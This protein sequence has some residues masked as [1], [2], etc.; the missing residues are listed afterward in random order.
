MLKNDLDYFDLIKSDFNKSSATYGKEAK[1]QKTVANSLCNQL[2]K[3]CQLS[4]KKILDI[5]CGSGFFADFLLRHNHTADNV[6]QLDIALDMCRQSSLYNNLV[7]NANMEY[8]PFSNNSF[9][10]IYSNFTMQWLLN[11]D[12]FFHNLHKIIKPNGIIFMSAVGSNTFVEMKSVAN[13]LNI[14]LPIMQ[15]LDKDEL[16]QILMLH[17][18]SDIEVRAKRI[19]RVY[20]NLFGLLVFIKNIGG[21]K[22]GGRSLSI[23]DLKALANSYQNKFAINNRI[24]ASWEVLLIKA[25]TV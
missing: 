19:V 23:S 17:G 16:L 4:D 12:Q 3:D 9:D 25:V 2:L 15:F 5:G 7:V 20:N 18:Y 13:E 22:K 8:L 10:V 11:V 1:L 6:Y 21:G 14:M 24:Y